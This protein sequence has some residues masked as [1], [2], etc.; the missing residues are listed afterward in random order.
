MATARGALR[1]SRSTVSP[2]AMVKASVASV[3]KPMR[4]SRSRY[5]PGATPANTNAPDASVSAVRPA[6]PEP[7]GPAPSESV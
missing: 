3:A 5:V 2:A 6:A 4:S 7:A 1:M